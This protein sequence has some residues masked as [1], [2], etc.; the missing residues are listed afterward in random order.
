M[1][2]GVGE[3]GHR[4]ESGNFL[5]LCLLSTPLPRD[6]RPQPLPLGEM[7]K[8]K[9]VVGFLKLPEDSPGHQEKAVGKG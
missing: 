6:F 9:V 5:S 7:V 1:E 4:R 8:V 2:V 3:E